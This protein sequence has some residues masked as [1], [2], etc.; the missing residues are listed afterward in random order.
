VLEVVGRRA[1]K[2]SI[3]PRYVTERSAASPGRPV[4]NTL[5][6]VLAQ[7]YA[8]FVPVAGSSESR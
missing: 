4:R 6:Q 2:L 7:P 5:D 8:V 3:V 1:R